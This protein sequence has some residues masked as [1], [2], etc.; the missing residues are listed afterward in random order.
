MGLPGAPVVRMSALVETPLVVGV[1]SPTVIVPVARF[2]QM[3]D[4]ERRMA[5]AHECAHIKRADLRV[6]CVPAFAEAVFFFHPLARLAAREYA[7]WRE[8]A[9]DAAVIDALDIPPAAYGRLLVGLGVSRPGVGLAAAGASWSS[10]NLKR[11][12]LMLTDTPV[13]STRS[14][15]APRW[16]SRSPASP[17]CRCN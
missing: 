9:C 15:V 8:A 6:G 14:R 12:L 1:L 4:V 11:R 3:N 7:L 16:R 10:S 5:L 2:R 17:S 13:R